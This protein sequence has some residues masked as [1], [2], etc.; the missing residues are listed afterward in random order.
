MSVLLIKI[1][2]QEILPKTQAGLQTVQRLFLGW[3]SVKPDHKFPVKLGT[4]CLTRDPVSKLLSPS[5]THALSCRIA[6]CEF[7]AKI[8]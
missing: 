7:C 4:E 8:T 3:D 2:C 6:P 5:V 1:V